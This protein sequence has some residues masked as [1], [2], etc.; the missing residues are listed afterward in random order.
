MKTKAVIENGL[1][2]T[3]TGLIPE[4]WE[5]TTLENE[6]LFEFTNGLWKGK[7]APFAAAKVIRNTNFNNDGT[8]SLDDVAELDVE[9]KQFIKRQLSG[10]D[11]I[12]E[13]SGGG[14]KQPVGRV[15]FFDLKEVNYSFSNFTT[16]IRIKD[17]N[18][19]Q[20]KYIL[21]YLL[22]FYNRGC[23]YELQQR[24]T[25]IRNLNFKDYKKTQVPL[26]SL[27]EQQKIAFVLSKIQQ[28]IEQQD[29]IIETTKELKKSL[30]HKL[31]TEGLHGEEQKETEIGL[32]PKS[33]KIV[34][35]GDDN[36]LGIVQY[37]ISTKGYPNGKYPMLRMNSL[38]DGHVNSKNLQFVNVDKD[39]FSKF[40]LE[41]GDVLFNRTN[42]I[43]LVGKTGIFN[44]KGDY[45]FASYLIRIRTNKKILNP[46]FLNLY[47]NIAASQ[48]R[49]KTLATRGVSQSNISG[50]RLKTFLI[51][52]PSI[53][54]EQ[55]EV[56]N[57]I[58]KA[59]RK[60]SHAE[61]TKQT[62]QALFRT[63]LNQLMTGKVRVKDFDFEV[64]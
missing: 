60:L 18:T 10:G 44:L 7:K 8:L 47:L 21:Y 15:V 23:T 52:L 17:I 34:R 50:S 51:P 28:A 57:I 46:M 32:M 42:S 53:L 33:W 30:L 22:H 20:P 64:N 13:R 54:D 24:T 49:L 45:I 61:S 43:D 59:D 16:R 14:P 25:G 39:L 27:T 55:E 1:K 40:K 38:V 19:M 31:F 11:I 9:E 41:D 2:V 37:G 4:D 5:T 35:L 56:V 6:K 48:E 3:E 12:L 29:R 26:L 58:S 63:M 62:L 36:I